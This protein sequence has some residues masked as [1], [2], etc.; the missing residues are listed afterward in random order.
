MSHH[1][2]QEIASLPA[3]PLRRQPSVSMGF[4]RPLV[5][6]V[7]PVLI[8]R[9]Y[10]SNGSSWHLVLMCFWRSLYQKSPK[11]SSRENHLRFK[12]SRVKPVRGSRKM[13][14]PPARSACLPLL[15]TK[16]PLNFVVMTTKMP[17][18]PTAFEKEPGGGGLMEDRVRVANMASYAISSSLILVIH[19]NM[20][21]GTIHIVLACLCRHF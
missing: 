18:R 16:L 21:N 15:V 4:K 11:N 3:F 5:S 19:D 20:I 6:C 9:Y 17:S 2:F 13:Q 10:I 7:Q 14:L 1:D 12:L 8:R